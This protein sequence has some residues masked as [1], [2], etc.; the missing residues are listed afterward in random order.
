MAFEKQRKQLEDTWTALQKEI[1]DL[2]Q[3][4]ALEAV[5]D[6]GEY[7][8]ANTSRDERALHLLRT[9]RRVLS[10]EKAL[11]RMA[12]GTYGICP[13]CKE[14]IAEERLNALPE[15]V[16]CMP[17]KA[18]IPEGPLDPIMR[19]HRARSNPA[20]RAPSAVQTFSSR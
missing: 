3:P 6:T 15:V 2:E 18:K 7:A 19:E 17:C 4:L 14:P 11:E 5:K 8:Q 12:K 9:R 16:L 20:K 1:S 10:I 13:S